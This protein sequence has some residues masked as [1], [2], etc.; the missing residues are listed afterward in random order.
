MMRR[1]IRDCFKKHRLMASEQSHHR[2]GGLAI[3][4]ESCRDYLFN[5]FGIDALKFRLIDSSASAVI[6]DKHGL[7][8]LMKIKHDLPSLKHIICTDKKE[9]DNDILSFDG[10]LN[11]SKDKYKN[12][13]TP[14][15][16]H[17]EK[18]RSG[19][20][21]FLLGIVILQKGIKHKKTIPILKAQNKIG[22]RDAFNPNLPKGYA[23]PKKNITKT[24]NDV[25]LKD[26]FISL[27]MDQGLAY[28]KYNTRLFLL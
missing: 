25:C 11:R 2:H 16:M 28:L 5:L 22:L 9:S 17:I 24:I 10:L 15:P 7:E 3:F 1:M 27:K 19:R 18:P 4:V 12:I 14:A 21:Y 8:K 13:F 20:K 6:C 23:L 26:N